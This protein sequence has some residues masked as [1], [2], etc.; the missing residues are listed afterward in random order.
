MKILSSTSAETG[1]WDFS[2]L[3]IAIHP[4]L[5]TPSIVFLYGNSNVDNERRNGHR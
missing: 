3:A 5:S 1:V 2:H 4:A